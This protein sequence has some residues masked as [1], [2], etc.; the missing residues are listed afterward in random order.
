MGSVRNLWRSSRSWRCLSLTCVGLTFPVE[1]HY[2]F[3]SITLKIILNWFLNFYQM[4]KG[5]KSTDI[6][7]FDRENFILYWKLIKSGRKQFVLQLGFS[8]G[9]PALNK[10]KM[11]YRKI[12]KTILVSVIFCST[13]LFN[14]VN[15][16]QSVTGILTKH[17]QGHCIFL[18]TLVRTLN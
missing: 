14:W 13:S 11:F 4:S 8:Y 5:M 12:G 7:K 6:I 15:S 16:G 2:T 3:S 17:R 1:T 18:W 10:M 9:F